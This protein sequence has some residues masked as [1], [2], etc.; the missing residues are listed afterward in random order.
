MNCKM[1][2]NFDMQVRY[3]NLMYCP[4]FFSIVGDGLDFRVELT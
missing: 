4:L 2:V 1:F 3:I